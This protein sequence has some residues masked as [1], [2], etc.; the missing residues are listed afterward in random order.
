[1]RFRRVFVVAAAAGMLAAACG[2]DGGESASTTAAAATTAAPATT[3]ASG[4]ATTAAPA[5][6]A[7]AG[8]TKVDPALP[9]LK[10]GFMI[11]ASGAN[12][13]SFRAHALELAIEELNAKGGA[14]G[15][16]IEFTEYD[17][18]T[19][20]DI[21]TVAVKKAISD[22]VNVI[23]GLNFSAMVPAAAPDIEASGI[24]LLH[25]AQSGSL[26]KSILKKDIGYRMGPTTDMYAEAFARYALDQ[27]PKPAKI[28]I[29]HTTDPNGLLAQ[30]V[31]VQYLKDNGF[32]GEVVE[33]SLAPNATDATEAV[34]GLK[35]VDFTIHNNV[36]A[37]GQVYMKQKAQNGITTPGVMDTG[38]AQYVSSGANT[39]AEMKN[40][41]YVSGCT[42]DAGTSPEA[43]AF[44]AAYLAKYPSEKSTDGVAPYYYQAAYFIAA[45]ANAAK[46]IEPAALKKAMLT[47]DLPGP[48]GQWKIDAENNLQHDIAVVSHDTGQL[49]KAYAQ[50]AGNPTLVA[51]EAAAAAAAAAAA[52]TTTKA[53]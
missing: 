35:D 12:A 30:K 24:P 9:P 49:I 43:K 16:K 28:G 25:V 17:I 45:A 50:V 13:L 33:R 27:N 20:A 47:L 22:K 21:S 8:P 40:M 39:A 42:T 51:S 6:T 11:Q 3:A 18:G 53:P 5:T 2:D 44:K 52:T 26:N 38:S 10:I 14:Y 1:M 19:T 34:L 7:A 36:P 48:C 15:H 41:S 37:V 23:L 31:I 4:A 29:E 32:T 46:S